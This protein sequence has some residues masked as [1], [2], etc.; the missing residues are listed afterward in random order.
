MSDKKLKE[1]AS[2]DR[3]NSIS[4]AVR[5]YRRKC[6]EK[7]EKSSK[8]CGSCIIVHFVIW[9]ML[10][11]KVVHTCAMQTMFRAQRSDGRSCYASSWPSHVARVMCSIIVILYKAVTCTNCYQYRSYLW[12]SDIYFNLQPT[13]LVVRLELRHKKCRTKNW[14]R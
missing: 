9:W 7:G 5:V 4:A 14:R 12:S 1:V 6:G 13:V 8:N 10:L 2:S 11:T 3:S